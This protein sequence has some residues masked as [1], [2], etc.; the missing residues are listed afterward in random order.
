M[1]V[2][3]FLFEHDFKFEYKERT[4][5]NISEFYAYD[6]ET[7]IYTYKYWDERAKFDN[8]I[9]DKDGKVVAFGV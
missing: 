6:T 4:N 5:A 1:L 7:G 9:Y 3:D 2:D 8:E